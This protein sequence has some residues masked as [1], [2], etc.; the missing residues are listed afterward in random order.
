MP[1]FTNISFSAS[2]MFLPMVILSKRTIRF[3]FFMS[4][5]SD[6]FSNIGAYSSLALTSKNSFSILNGN[7]VSTTVPSGRNIFDA[8]NEMFVK[9]GIKVHYIDGSIDVADRERI[10]SELENT[11]GNILVAQAVTASVGLNIRNLNGIAFAFAGRSFVRVIQSIGRVIRLKDD[12]STSQLFELYFNTRY[13]DAHHDE[14][15]DILK[16]Q[17]GKDC[18]KRDVVVRI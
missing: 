2:N 14:K 18:I 17:Y 9:D 12:G 15:M 10:R 1:S 6:I 11:N 3:R 16:S 13:S 7:E 8:L 5:N 4:N